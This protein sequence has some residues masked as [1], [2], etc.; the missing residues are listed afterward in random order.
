MQQ[1]TRFPEY[2][3]QIIVDTSGKASGY[4]AVSRNKKH[5]QLSPLAYSLLEKVAQG[6]SFAD[7]AREI[8]AQGSGRISPEEVQKAYEA[9]TEKIKKIDG[10]QG[11]RQR[12]FWLKIS[13]LP[14]AKVQ[15]IASHLTFLFQPVVA[16]VLLGSFVILGAYA[17]EQHVLQHALALDPITVLVAYLLLLVSLC[18]HEFGHSSACVRGGIEPSEIGAAIYLVFPVFYS[19]VSASWQLSRWKKVR[20]DTGGVYF[21]LCAGAVYLLLFM[22]TQQQVFQVALALVLGSCFISLN[23]ILK[24]D[25]Y[26]V[27]TDLLGIANLYKQPLYLATF[28]Y[29]RVIRKQQRVLRWSVGT[30]LFILLYGL[31]KAAFWIYFLALVLPSLWHT[32]IT[33]PS[34]LALAIAHERM[35]RNTLFLA[36]LRGL[37]ASGLFML[38][39]IGGL[40]RV[41]IPLFKRF[42]KKRQK[43]EQT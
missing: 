18:A 4:I 34:L 8:S 38:L 17:W 36:D 40:C 29:Q 21:Q 10:E 12:D 1:I 26:W 2:I 19:D 37:L 13:L 39:W 5:I 9:V 7:I 27:L 30:T 41:C 23:P 43:A 15:H 16:F 28:F 22:V 25:G 6:S 24:F 14:A 42:F 20:V 11:A 3:E 32:L 33:G 31:L 35:G